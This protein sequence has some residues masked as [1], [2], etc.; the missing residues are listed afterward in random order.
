MQLQKSK[1]ILLSLVSSFSTI[2]VMSLSVVTMPLVTSQPAHAEQKAIYG[3]IFKTWA[4]MG[5]EG[6][7]LGSPTTDELP[8]A[9][10]G[11]FNEFQRGLIYWHPNFGE[12][13]A[14]YG[15]I[16]EKWKSLGRE[17]G[18]GYPS[19]DELPAAWGGRFSEFEKTKYIY[20]HPNTGAHLVYGDIGARWNALGRERSRLGYPISDEEAAGSAGNRV[21]KF[22][23]GTIHWEAASRRTFVTYWK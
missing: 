21:T 12:A 7:I 10:G 23:G 11:R 17:N 16:G 4:R 22:Q 15:L 9:R 20:W 5:G 14:I 18:V 1:A 19:T 2:S 8:A 6:G 3:E 13:H